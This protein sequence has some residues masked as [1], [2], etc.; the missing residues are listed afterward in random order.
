MLSHQADCCAGG[1]GC[2][3]RVGEREGEGSAS[4][5]CAEAVAVQHVDLGV[6]LIWVSIGAG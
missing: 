5:S 2:A 3:V 6:T 1:R 4:R